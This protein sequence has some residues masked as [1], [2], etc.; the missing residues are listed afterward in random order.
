ML[1]E[2]TSNQ[3]QTFLL[4]IDMKTSELS[5]YN[6][7]QNLVILIACCLVNLFC[8][9]LKIKNIIISIGICGS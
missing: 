3:E 5:N 1:T 7:G 6:Y 9:F 4:C 2:Q 8:T